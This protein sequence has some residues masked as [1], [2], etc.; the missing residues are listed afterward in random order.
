ML[1]KLHLDKATKKS[2]Q[3]SADGIGT[4]RLIKPAG[5]FG[6]N[7]ILHTGDA[8]REQSRQHPHGTGVLLGRQTGSQIKK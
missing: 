6:A 5:A 4:G 7:P 8:G 1:S 2:L 3:L